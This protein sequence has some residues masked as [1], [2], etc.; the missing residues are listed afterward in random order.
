MFLQHYN[1]YINYY[2][3]GYVLHSDAS[4]SCRFSLTS[5]FSFPV[6]YL[7]FS[8]LFQRSVFDVPEICHNSTE[9][10]H[11]NTDTD[12]SEIGNEQGLLICFLGTE[13][14]KTK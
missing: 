14:D 3:L 13:C 1:I 7:S 6:S 11:C 8:S 10:L 12:D 9:D 2:L 5:S 4:L